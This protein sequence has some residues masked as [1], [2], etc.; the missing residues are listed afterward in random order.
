MNILSHLINMTCSQPFQYFRIS[1]IS[2]F[3]NRLPKKSDLHFSISQSQ[4]RKKQ[5]A[6]TDPVGI[7]AGYLM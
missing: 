2:G 7:Y 1:Q 6:L 3:Q 4:F 5:F